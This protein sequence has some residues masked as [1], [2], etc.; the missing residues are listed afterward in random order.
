VGAR[1]GPR[2]R[3]VFATPDE[4][5]EVNRRKKGTARRQ[6]RR[7]RFIMIPTALLE[8]QDWTHLPAPARA[9]FIDVCKIHHHGGERGPSN[10][11]R[12]GYGCVAGAKAANASVATAYRMLNEL[13]KGG[14]LKLRKK[15]AFK[16]KAGEGRAH[17]W[18]ITIF[19]MAGRPPII[20]GERKLHIEH[21]LLDSAAFKGLSSQA[22]CILIE[23]MRRYDGGNNGSISFG[24]PQGAYAG[25]SDDVTGRALGELRRARFIVQTEPAVAYLCRPRKWRLTIY[26]ADGKPATKDFMR[27]P[28]PRPENSDHDLAG[29]VDSRRNASMM[30]SSLSSNLAMAPIEAPLSEEISNHTK[31][32]VENG[33]S[34]DNRAGETFDTPDTRAREIHLEAS[35][36]APRRTGSLASYAPPLQRFSPV[37][38]DPSEQAQ[39]FSATAISAEAIIERPADLFGDTL[40]SVPTPLDRLRLELR[41]VLIRKRGTQSRLAEVLGLS[42]QT[43]ANALS[44]RERF[45]TTAAAALHRWLHG[46]PISGNWPVLPAVTEKPDAA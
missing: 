36:P 6:G 13:R 23:L 34:L 37:P 39:K 44:G 24:G 1:S 9:I 8:H 41:A 20:W 38:A 3:G 15:G 16:I 19:P 30:R 12:I 31:A 18:E 11:G 22:K 5:G 45:T 4:A 46:E 25:F 10:N 32:L 40:P 42:R 21:W 17:E 35:P 27:D 14:L 26:P 33:P 2:R 29:A 7:E 28:K 43:F